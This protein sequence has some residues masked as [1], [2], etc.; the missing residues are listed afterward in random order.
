MKLIIIL[1]CLIFLFGCASKMEVKQEQ[2]R[3]EKTIG[4][5]ENIVT[6]EEHNVICSD[7][8]AGQDLFAKGVTYKDQERFEDSCTDT[9]WVDKYYCEGSVLKKKNRLCP[10]HFECSDGACIKNEGSIEHC[11]D[12][13]GNNITRKGSTQKG[14]EQY[15]DICTSTQNVKEYECSENKI[16]STLKICSPGMQCSDGACVPYATICIDKDNGLNTTI[17]SE[18]TI[19]K[20]T[21]IRDLYQD[22]CISDSMVREYYCDTNQNVNYS[23]TYCKTGS[24]CANG[25][26]EEVIQC[27]ENDFG[28][29][30]KNR[31]TVTLIERR[32]SE[33]ETDTYTDECVGA[34]GVLTEY[35]CF[36]N[37]AATQQVVCSSGCNEGACVE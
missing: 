6:Q 13:D 32:G 19:D 22:T 25:A 14:T 9:N 29:D 7:S 2:P 35:Y 11:K 16:I 10:S 26:C 1:V 27:S 30:S 12:T 36:Q 20:G 21:G 24:S 4:K 23:D 37:E 17:A 8:D 34:S 28:F 33:T 3:I 18:V 31:G 15:D 5:K